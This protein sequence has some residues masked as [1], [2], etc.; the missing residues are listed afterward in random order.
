MRRE[1]FCLQTHINL[2]EKFND[3]ITIIFPRHINRVFKIKKLSESLNLKTQLLNEDE[4]FLKD[5]EIIIVNSFG[6]LQK[7]FYYAKSV[8][9][10]K[11]ILR[12]LKNVGGQNPIEAVKLGCKIYHGPY[13]YNFKEI[14]EILAKKLISVQIENPSELSSN[15]I[16]DFENNIKNKNNILREIDEVGKRGFE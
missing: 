4:T 7:Y 16:M 6:E 11:S 15:L 14:Y 12:G 8:F 9:M 10:G 13:V 1:N 2:K 3:I 5:K